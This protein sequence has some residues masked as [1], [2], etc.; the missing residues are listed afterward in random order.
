V[1]SALDTVARRDLYLLVARLF[2]EEVDDALYRRLLAT[3][4]DG[5]VW[6]EPT[7]AELPEARA[8]EALQI[9]YCR[10]FIGPNPVCP[11]FASVMRGEAVLGGRSRTTLDELL[12][13]HGLAVDDGARLASPD[14]VAVVFA[15]LAELSE[16]EA[17]RECLRRLVLPWVPSW[18]STLEHGTEHALFRTLA[19][20]AAALIDE[21]QAH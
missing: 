5:L 11:P 1:Q 4:R 6:I 9:E 7:L 19:R 2:Q 18:L 8:I 10:L 20:L 3:Q 17:V 13:S 12:A 14:H 21:D 15:I 16:P